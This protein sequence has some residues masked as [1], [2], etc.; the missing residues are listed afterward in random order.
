MVA[1]SHCEGPSPMRDHAVLSTELASQI[2]ILIGLGDVAF[3]TYHMLVIG[4]D[5]RCV[6]RACQPSRNRNSPLAGRSH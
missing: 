5:F 3:I 6:F 1:E 2:S 4:D